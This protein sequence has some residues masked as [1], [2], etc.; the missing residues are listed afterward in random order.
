[1]GFLLVGGSR[2]L[3]CTFFQLSVMGKEKGRLLMVISGGGVGEID[4]LWDALIL[5]YRDE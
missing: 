5:R 1:M 4:L 3:F 2:S